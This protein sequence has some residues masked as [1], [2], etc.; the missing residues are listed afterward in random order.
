MIDLY[1]FDPATKLFIE[2]RQHDPKVRLP[3]NTTAI[4]KPSDANFFTGSMWVYKD[5]TSIPDA[6]TE[7]IPD[8]PQMLLTVLSA[9]NVADN[10]DVLQTCG[11][12]TVTEGTT[13][14]ITIQISNLDEQVL[15]VSQ[16]FV[17]P[18]AGIAGAISRAKRVTFVD[19]VATSDIA[20]NQSGLWEVTENEVN[21]DIPS[22][23]NQFKFDGLRFKIYET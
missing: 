12:V 9:V 1:Y 4:V 17:L 5:P 22:I 14:R 3:D 23:A 8:S 19:G 7:V 10:T 15:P 13:V 16:D 11:L 20:F 21:A 18:I 6:S 2:T